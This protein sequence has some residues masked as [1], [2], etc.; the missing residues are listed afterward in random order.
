MIPYD[1]LWPNAAAH[2]GQAEFW[3]PTGAPASDHRVQMRPMLMM[4]TVDASSST[5]YRTR[6]SPAC[7]R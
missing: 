1:W 3:H 4:Y 7:S 6:T 2:G 5:S